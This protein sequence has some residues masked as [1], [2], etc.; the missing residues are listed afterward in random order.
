MF[1]LYD[2]KHNT[3]IVDIQVYNAY[4]LLFIYTKFDNLK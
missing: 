4:A 2:I 3:L 1:L